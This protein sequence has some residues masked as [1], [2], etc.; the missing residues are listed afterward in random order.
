MTH[1]DSYQVQ[2]PN[3]APRLDFE[4][5]DRVYSFLLY[6][7]NDEERAAIGTESVLRSYLSSDSAA[8]GDSA[9]PVELYR[10]ARVEAER[11]GRSHPEGASVGSKD[12]SP[13]E[14]VAR[15]SD[16]LL[17]RDRLLLGLTEI[18]RLS[19]ADV[20]RALGV[21]PG[22]IDES[23]AKMRSRAERAIGPVLTARLGSEFCDDLAA[24][25]SDWSGVFDA[26]VNRRV[27]QHI[28]E[29]DSCPE[30]LAFVMEPDNLL[31]GILTVSAPERIHAM[32]LGE[33]VEPVVSVSVVSN[34][35]SPRGPLM[36]AVF[37]GLA[38]ILGLIGLA[39]AAQFEPLDSP[40]VFV[41]TTAPDPGAA[42]TT[43]STTT[44]VPLGSPATTVPPG[45][46]TTVPPG[47]TASFATAQETIDFGDGGL[48]ATLEITNTG[49]AAGRWTL[50]TS[51]GAIG[52]SAAQ[53][54]LA[55]GATS[56]VE[57][58][59]D[60]GQ[61]EEGDLAE[62]L[63]VSWEGGSIEVGVTG[64]HEDN[65]VIHNPRVSPST[66]AV[67][68]GAEC[69]PTQT[70]VS[71]RIRD[72]SALERVI[73][74]WSPDGSA[75]VETAMIDIGNDIWEGV[76]GPFSAAQSASPRIVAFDERGNAGGAAVS[77]SVTACP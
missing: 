72:T 3:G 13:L 16:G 48:A 6:T 5:V 8:L 71:A 37:A 26:E 21:D 44:T 39:V 69:S 12:G 77:L 76:I 70:T 45:P 10:L 17:E 42:T 61:I 35:R 32:A 34:Q 9:R 19:G 68:G 62:T 58:Q 36:Y 49:D 56:A 4:L 20:A 22:G 75:T 52:F 27:A 46:T 59:L 29:C 51:N 74:R 55:P 65:P 47:A 73:V 50:Q 28:S 15:A 18:A 31:P 14:L 1:N 7:V 33:T 41:P 23:I 57:L 38:V 30:R 67:D 54:D 11:L 60:R 66:V 63:T 64:S 2:S 43:T 40:P 24:T 53:G 25:V